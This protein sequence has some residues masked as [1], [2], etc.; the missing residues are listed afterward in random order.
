MFSIV[1]FSVLYFVFSTGAP[2][3][4]GL[5]EVPVKTSYMTLHSDANAVDKAFGEH[6]L[7]AQHRG[8]KQVTTFAVVQNVVSD[9]RTVLHRL[10][11]QIFCCIE[12]GM[13]SSFSSFSR[14]CH[15]RDA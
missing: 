9:E 13:V 4:R 12:F 7:S 3:A 5:H 6:G 10:P 1:L 11:L 15:H 8:L 2:E 14:L